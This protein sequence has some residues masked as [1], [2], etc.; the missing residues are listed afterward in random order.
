MFPQ[1]LWNVREADDIQKEY[2]YI[3]RLINMVQF[4]KRL[5][6][7]QPVN[8]EQQFDARGFNV[9]G[10]HRNG[11]KYDDEGYDVRGFN[12]TGKTKQRKHYDENGF[13][14]KGVHLTGKKYVAGYDCFGYDALGFNKEGRNREGFYK[15]GFNKEGYD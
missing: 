15:D 2:S 11:T 3:E 6:S 13:D 8:V 1:S 12:K 14:A 7:S 10:D 5:F 4:F 9:Y